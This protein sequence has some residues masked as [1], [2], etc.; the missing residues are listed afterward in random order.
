MDFVNALF[1]P[2][3]LRESL[4]FEP[5]STHRRTDWGR[6]ELA[7]LVAAEDAEKPVDDGELRDPLTQPRPEREERRAQLEA[8][9]VA[10]RIRALVESRVEVT[11]PGGVHHAIGYDDVIV[12]ARARTHVQW[13]ERALTAAQI[14]FTGTA[15]GSLLETA[16]ARD[17]TALLRWL[18][19]PHRDLELA[20]VL[21][22]P[23][24]SLSD[25]NLIALARDVKTNGGTWSEALQRLS[26]SLPDLR[27]A[28]A[29]LLR[30]QPL[31][32]RLPAHDLLD[33]IV[34]EANAA[35]RY[36]AALPEIP[37]ARVRAN[38]GAFLQL[39]L[40][41]DS[42]RFPSLSRFLRYLE[43]QA[44]SQKDAPDEAPP[45]ASAGFVRIMTIHAAKGL[46]APAVFISTAAAC[47][48]SAP[49]AGW[50]SGRIVR[51]IPPASWRRATAM[52]ATP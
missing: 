41:A 39:A 24:F 20:Q 13:L 40:E 17:L 43:E 6:V 21:R 16:E 49:R 22:S 26:M 31:A 2:E 9:Q 28:A 34:C 4:G 1:E 33:G 15:R 38:L 10:Q 14:P 11:G 3:V 48:S 51:S 46:E 45:A 32:A 42:G 52:H 37:K 29:L 23:L 44:R 27:H 12:L 47:R 50:W 30:W 18:D 36:E 8:A 5:H 35:A 19:A 25:E 7:P